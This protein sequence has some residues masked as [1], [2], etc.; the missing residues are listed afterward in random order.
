MKRMLVYLATAVLAVPACRQPP[1]AGAPAA[2]ISRD[3]SS[4]SSIERQLDRW[5]PG[6]GAANLVERERPQQELEQLCLRA[7]RP[8]AESQRTW[9]CRA[10]AA[11]LGPEAP[12]PARVWLLRQLERIGREECVSAVAALLDEGD[13][14]IRDLARRVL[15]NNPSASAGAA[16]RGALDKADDDPAWQIALINALAARRDPALAT[17]LAELADH[18]D[19]AVTKAAIA[20]LADIGTRRAVDALTAIWRGADQERR[21]LAAAALVR[22][23]DQFVEAGQKPRAASL[24]A[25]VYNPAVE[26]Q[27]RAAALRG[28]AL[29]DP[30]QAM[31]LL[32]ESIRG[33]RDPALQLLAVRLLADSAA[34]EVTQALAAELPDLPPEVQVV[35]LDALAGRGDRNL[36]PA[37]IKTLA[38][39]DAGVR[40]AALEALQVL[41]DVA[42]IVLLATV[43]AQSS[44]AEREAARRSLARMRG[45]SVDEVIL[46]DVKG[47]PPGLR[48]E[49]IEALRARRFKTALSMFLREACHPDENV[50]VAALGAIGELGSPEDA[51]AVLGLLIA[52]EGD[53]VRS[54]AEDA[55]VALCLRQEEPEHRADPVLDLWPAAG[56]RARASLVSVLGRI[57]GSTALATIRTARNSEDADVVDAAVRALAQWAA[58]DVLAD[59]LEI[60][61]HSERKAHRVLAL[62]GYIRL[63]GLP[64]EREPQDTV[65]LYHRALSLAERPEE[66]KQV[67]SGLSGVVHADALKVARQCR[68]DENL[69]AEADSAVLSIARLVGPWQPAEA[70]AAI[71]E[72]VAQTEDEALHERA[73]KI[74]DTIRKSAGCILTWA[75]SGPYFLEEDRAGASPA[76]AWMDVYDT[77]FPPEQP[78]STGDELLDW[79]PLKTTNVYQPWVFD[80]TQLESGSDRC[81]YA[82]SAVWSEQAR[83]VRLEVGSDDAVKVWL[84]DQLVHEFRAVRAHEALQD[85]V[86][87]CIEAGWN[88]LL[89][90]VVQA[91]GGW[92]FSCA[93]R[94]PD[95]EPLSGLLIQAEAPAGP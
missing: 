79:R 75:L 71:Q 45:E 85:H 54:A 80:L 35:A 87:V 7:G 11:R 43:A 32:L 47:A 13:T 18:P 72:V 48:A 9:L 8:G 93:L 4:Q 41:G 42:D 51:G 2:D 3:L 39:D 1:G 76:E 5:L 65:A 59:L 86:A 67:L 81:V 6:M 40:I 90:K 37:V 50:R 23:A 52:A 77:A 73:E 24:Y 20:G 15:Q 60:V 17:P 78:A 33:Q 49:L 31:P 53:A 25:M 27:L 14:E 94:S 64:S 84:N 91:G 63:L 70:E 92:G 22:V 21:R 95:G 10:M 19:L 46:A 36:K 61:R 44:G 74:L 26:E 66:R 62:E 55:A 58:T 16:L 82:R 57:G 34:P 30:A 28:L 83:D 29:A 69:R 68:M 56:A 12:G 89:L 38:S 88:T